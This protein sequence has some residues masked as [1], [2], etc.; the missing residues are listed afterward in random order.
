MLAMMQGD[1]TELSRLGLLAV[2]ALAV[3]GV[4]LFFRW[5]GDITKNWIV[6]GINYL[7]SEFGP[8]FIAEMKE[9]KKGQMGISDAM[10]ESANTY[11]ATVSEALE[12]TT[13][14][15]ERQAMMQD[16]LMASHKEISTDLKVVINKADTILDRLKGD[17]Q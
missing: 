17:K 3:I 11:K 5:L 9:I 12:H 7:I 1:V 8:A 14:V 16:S 13:K 10:T 2:G 15:Q 4:G 6:K